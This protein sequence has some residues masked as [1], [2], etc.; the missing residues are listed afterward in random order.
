MKSKSIPIVLFANFVA[1][2]SLATMT[3]AADLYASYIW[4]NTVHRFGADGAD[5]GT[6]ASAGLSWPTG[7]AFTSSGNLLVAN[8]MSN[9][10]HQF[11]PTGADLGVFNQ[12]FVSTPLDLAIDSSDYLFASSFF[13]NLYKLA[14]NG[15]VLGTFTA[16][17][18][19]NWSIAVNPSGNVFVA[20]Y[21]NATTNTI[22]EFGP[23]GADLGAFVS[24][25]GGPKIQ[26]LAFNSSGNLFV[27]LSDNTIHQFGPTGAD[28]G[29]FASAGPFTP[30]ALAFD[31]SD[32]LYVVYASI[33]ENTIHKFGPTGTDLG[34]F[35]N[36][37]A[38]IVQYLTFSRV[39]EP[40]TFALATL[41]L[42]GLAACVWRRKR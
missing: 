2:M 35:A 11:S 9:Y 7:L 1:A 19:V 38:H 5:L 32:N 26:D 29:T 36:P 6:F 4:E 21:P 18:A 13:G 10:I 25:G 17:W 34:T 31:A 3:Q 30:K 15:A 8:Q 16:P 24:F 14:P 39:P 20:T 23:N 40:S 22:Q 28:L 33:F 41:C 42:I 27:S 12:T 37:G